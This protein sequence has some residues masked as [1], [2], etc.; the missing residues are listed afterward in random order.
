[1][2]CASA[3][4]LMLLAV[5]MAATNDDDSERNNRLKIDHQPPVAFTL[6]N[7]HPVHLKNNN[8]S[9]VAVKIKCIK[10]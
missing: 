7:H 9:I 6:P 8:S 3:K 10:F 4:I 5:I 1:M 2:H